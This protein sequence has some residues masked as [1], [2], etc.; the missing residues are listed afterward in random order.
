MA[1]LEAIASRNEESEAMT[2]IGP[3]GENETTDETET[4]GEPGT[5]NEPGTVDE[6]EPTDQIGPVR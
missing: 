6:T 2:E 3:V 1:K 4:T 5:T